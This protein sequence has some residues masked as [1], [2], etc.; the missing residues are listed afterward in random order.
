MSKSIWITKEGWDA[1]NAEME[2]LWKE[3]RMVAD[4]VGEAAAMG[5]RS[6]NAEYIYGR[7]KLREVDRRISYIHRRFK[8]LKVIENQP[9]EPGKA[10][11]GSW[12]E[13]KDP[14]GKVFKFQIVGSDEADPKKKKMSVVS[15]IGKALVDRM[16]G[17]TVDVQTPAGKRVFTIISVSDTQS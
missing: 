2:A 3:R 7:K 12:I 15:P 14:T 11:F 1:L 4:A 6:E 13:F 8:V 10:I 5:D 16:V 17:E 9:K